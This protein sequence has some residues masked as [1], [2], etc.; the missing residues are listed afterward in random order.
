[1]CV[2]C[3]CLQAFFC[4]LPLAWTGTGGKIFVVCTLKSFTVPV[5][6]LPGS[7]HSLLLSFLCTAR[8]TAIPFALPPQQRRANERQ[9][10]VLLANHASVCPIPSVR[11]DTIWVTDATDAGY[12]NGAFS[13][14]RWSLV[15]SIIAS[16]LTRE[17]CWPLC[18]I[19]AKAQL[20]S[21]FV[22]NALVQ[23]NEWRRT[24]LWW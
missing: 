7:F 20:L 22:D 15:T 23:S 4:P 2:S 12:G 13:R 24:S 9:N 18:Y 14:H 5:L 10:W 17:Y 19:W 16:E 1:M 11:R 21:P 8:P 3:C 6:S